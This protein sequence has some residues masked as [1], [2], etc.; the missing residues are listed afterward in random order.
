MAS[1]LKKQAM[2]AALKLAKGV[3]VDEDRERSPEEVAEIARNARAF[4]EFAEQVGSVPFEFASALNSGMR[5]APRD[6]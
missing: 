3:G 1:F 4:A 2:Q 5:R 6:G